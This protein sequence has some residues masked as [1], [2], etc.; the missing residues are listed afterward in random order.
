MGAGFRGGWGVKKITPGSIQWDIRQRNGL[1]VGFS[2]T[3]IPGCLVAE[4]RH[5]DYSAPLCTIWYELHSNGLLRI[6]SMYTIDW[7][8]RQGL[9]TW[10]ME[11]VKAIQSA[12][13]V[14]LINAE[15]EC[16]IVE[17]IEAETWPR[18]WD[19]TE[20]VADVPF[21]NVNPDG[22]VQLALAVAL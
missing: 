9:A 22:S 21:E 18:G 8:R 19:G 17:L 3:S 10:L 11:R 16:R 20:P 5:R 1:S 6:N 13:G 7:A 2:Y 15:E 12:A 4:A 14:D